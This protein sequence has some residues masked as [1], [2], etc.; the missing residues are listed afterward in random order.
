MT[1]MVAS[2]W[3]DIP[4][5]DYEGHMALPE[6]AQAR[7]LADELEIAVRQH[8]PSSVAI[9]GCSG[10]NG[11]ERLIGTTVERVV[12]LDINPTYVAAAQARFGTQMP[13]LALYVADIQDSLPN[14]A[15]VEMIFAG[16]IFEYVDLHTAMHNLRRLCAQ[17]GTLVAVLQA[18]SAEAK[19][20]SPS[21]YRSLQQ[22]APA[23]RLRHPQEMKGAAVEAG[24]APATMRSFTLP[25]RKSFIVMSFDR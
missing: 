18:P 24:L 6:I 15:P 8:A 1:E 3:L 11:F 20:V 17:G 16:L 10:G 13:K 22:L 4:L 7:M 21:P 14:I 2:P 9:I 19:A 12:G 5:A 23:M 25:S